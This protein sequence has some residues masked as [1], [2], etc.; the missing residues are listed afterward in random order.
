MALTP[1]LGQSRNNIL[2]PWDYILFDLWIPISRIW[3]ALDFGALENPT[4]LFFKDV[5]VIANTRFDKGNPKSHI[6]TACITCLKKEEVKIE[7][8][9]KSTLIISGDQ[10]REEVKE[11]DQ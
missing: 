9:D 8:R 10:D 2:W 3:D 11:L 1:F 4:F 6:F 7:L 5:D